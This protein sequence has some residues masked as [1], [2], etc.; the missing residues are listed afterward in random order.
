LKTHRD[1]LARTTL[2]LNEEW[3]GGEAHE[4]AIAD[5]LLA[6]T[7]RLVADEHALSCRA[8][9]TALVTSF[10]LTARLGIGIELRAPNP[11]LIDR[12][13]PLTE[14]RLQDALVEL[15]GDLI[16]GSRVRTSVGEVQET[17]VFGITN[18]ATRSPVRV[19][20][21][22][23]E[24]VL[25]RGGD[26]VPC[27]GNGPLG[28]LAAGAAV[29][30][31]ALEAA[32]ERVEEATGLAART[33]RP[34][35]GPPVQIALA[36]LFPGLA[37]GSSSELGRLDAISGGAITHALA[38]CLL[39]V[40]KLRG[41]VRVIEK[42]DADIS[43]VNRYSLLRASHEH[44]DKVTLLEAAG[45]DGLQIGGVRTL[46]MK[47]SRERLLPLADRVVVGVDDV[48]ARWWVQE[49]DPQWLAIGATSNHLAQLTIHVPSSPCAACI[50]PVAP[51]PGT[52]PTISFVSFWA[53]LLQACALLS[54]G[55]EPRNLTIFPF[56]L[57]GLSPV[58]SASPAANPACPIE[59]AR[60]QAEKG[61]WPPAR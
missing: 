52:I 3:F 18:E 17:F 56:A 5:A 2:L 54:A 30:A 39:R 41:K 48:E 15:G 42:Q 13:A 45:T 26:G 7:V 14:A 44:V 6:S 12:V 49:A 4:D 38:F 55:A 51:A 61:P 11:Q 58:I 34:T 19:G 31:I 16:P 53:G 9:Q 32:R 37:Q 24:A 43:N 36:E 29:A 46:F 25:A 47:D 50:H 8:G 10:M 57:G 35:P 21:T 27:S 59:C 23:L 33:P 60:S 20:A 40:P 1:A 22:D 28:G